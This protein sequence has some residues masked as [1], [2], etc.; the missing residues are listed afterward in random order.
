MKNFNP[1]RLMLVLV[2]FSIGCAPAGPE[3][4]DLSY[5]GGGGPSGSGKIGIAKFKDARENTGEGYIGFRELSF[6]REETYFVE[7]LD[8][9]ASV[10]RAVVSYLE[11]SGYDCSAI[12]KWDFSES[13][14]K[15]ASDR[16]DYI[17]GGEILS[18]DCTARKNT[19]T[20]IQ[21]EISL[22]IHLGDVTEQELKSV[23][24]EFDLE[25]REIKLS[26][27]KMENMLNRS[28]EEVIENALNS[29]LSA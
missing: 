29:N 17:I 28:L 16:F 21:M 27:R 24:I 25:R 18:F 7:G 9:A 22:V 1:V 20:H 3:F 2:F 26:V 6:N 10:T 14:M 23:P 13:G 11:Q 12:E 15:N 8:L 19:T 5:T 4:V